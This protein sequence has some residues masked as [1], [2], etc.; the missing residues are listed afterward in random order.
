LAN[1]ETFDSIKFPCC[2]ITTIK[3]PTARDAIA[4]GYYLRNVVDE[5]LP[6]LNYPLSKQRFQG[7]PM[8]KI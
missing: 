1:E 4:P 8:K 5:I 6:A 3:Y 7:T 2:R